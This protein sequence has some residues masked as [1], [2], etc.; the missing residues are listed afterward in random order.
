MKYT[1]NEQRIIKQIGM[2]FVKRN[3]D[4]INIGNAYIQARE[5]IFKLGITRIV[6]NIDLSTVIIHLGRPGLLI[7]KKGEQINALSEHLKKYN[8]EKVEII[9]DN[10]FEHLIPRQWDDFE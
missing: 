7:G 3:I 5:D 10:L 8:V 1:E 9:E 2:F 6:F 4:K